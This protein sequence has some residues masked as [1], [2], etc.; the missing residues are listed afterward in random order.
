M[1]SARRWVTAWVM[2]VGLVAWMGAAAGG[3]AETP[4]PQVDPEAGTVTLAAQ[5]AEQGKYDVLKG[6]IEYLLVS[7]DGKSYESVLV[8][9]CTPKDLADALSAAKM[10]SGKPAD[11]ENGPGGDLLRIW[12]E[13]ERDGKAVREPV[14]R[15]VLFTGTGK[16][17]ADGP[18]TFAGSRSTLDPKTNQQ[19]LEASV[20]GSLVGL[21][22]LD[23]S[24]VIQNPRPEARQEN[25]Y[26]TNL[27]ELPKAGTAVK[28]V[29]EKVKPKVPQGARHVHV[30]VSGRVQGVGFRAF[31]QREALGLELTGWV[32]NLQ[33]GRVEAV[34]EG[35]NEKVAQL[36][37]QIKR[38]PRAAQVAKLDAQDEPYEGTH[39][40]F[41]IRY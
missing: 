9:D 26:R 11:E 1:R 18:W 5:V 12:V 33:D 2:S 22:Y 25:V 21:H 14:E 32:K 24:S 13:Y 3:A 31:V 23:A 4:K 34:V 17:M 28:L 19:V 40:T 16:P 6:A 29:L 41:E 20:T 10:K 15:F 35:P 30:F 8:T 37:E 36:L 27:P 7:R 39:Q 38:G